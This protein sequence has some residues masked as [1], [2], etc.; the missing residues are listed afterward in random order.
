MLLD[1]IRDDPAF[2]ELIADFVNAL[3]ARMDQLR[4]ANEASDYET[5]QTIA[6]QLKGAGGGYGFDEITTV[7]SVVESLAK[8][9]PQGNRDKLTEQIERFAAI[10]ET[11]R[12]SV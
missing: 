7:A 3:P 1:E 8:S 2:V 12:L 6:H 11:A 5:I 10:C 4:I 9:S